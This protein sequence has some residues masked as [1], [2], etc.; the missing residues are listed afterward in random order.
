MLRQ[1]LHPVLV[2]G[3]HALNEDGV[4]DGCLRHDC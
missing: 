3:L 1:A 2:D 4:V